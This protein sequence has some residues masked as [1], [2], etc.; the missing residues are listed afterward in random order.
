METFTPSGRKISPGIKL[1]R[2]SGAVSTI[3]TKFDQVLRIILGA[4]ASVIIDTLKEKGAGFAL[5]QH[6]GIS[7]K[8]AKQRG[9]VFEQ[10]EVV[11]LETPEPERPVKAA[12]VCDVE[13][14]E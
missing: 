13:N 7:V 3:E 6:V 12:V 1:G 10:K 8:W 14:F 9:F 5:Q 11:E 2:P 4:D